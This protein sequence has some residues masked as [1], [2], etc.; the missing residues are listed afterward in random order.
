MALFGDLRRYLGD[1]I[2]CFSR[3]IDHFGEAFPVDPVV[4]DFG[5]PE[6]FVV[7]LI[8]SRKILRF[9]ISS[10]ISG[11][12]GVSRTIGR[13]SKRLS[14]IRKR[15]GSSP[16]SPR[17]IC[18]FCQAEDGIRDKLVTGV[19]TCAL[20]ISFHTPPCALS[21]RTPLPDHGRHTS[22]QA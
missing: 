11:P 3:T 6:F 17:P 21:A 1:L 7:H 5:K 4:I 20:P 2:R 13:F 12:L 15:N 9:S 16:S 14:F 22:Q 10:F 18:S 19:Q 8:K